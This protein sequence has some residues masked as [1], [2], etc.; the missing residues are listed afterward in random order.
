MEKDEYYHEELVKKQT[1]TDQDILCL[2]R[3]MEKI[4]MTHHEKYEKL[5]LDHEYELGNNFT[6]N[7]VLL[8]MHCFCLFVLK[9]GSTFFKSELV[10]SSTVWH[11][12]RMYHAIFFWN[13][14]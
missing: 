3:L 1:V 11:I 4:D 9:K 2:R 6:A 7:M 10:K 12:K 13:T 8:Y 5:V 14:S